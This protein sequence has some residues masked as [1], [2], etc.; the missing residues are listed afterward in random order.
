MHYQIAVLTTEYVK[1][2]MEHCLS[3]LDL[4]CSFQIC[5][6]HP[7]EDIEPV[8]HAIPQ[9]A[10]AILS[11]GKVFAEAISHDHPEDGRPLRPFGVD[12][13]AVHRLLWRLREESGELDC[14]RI[15]TDFLDLLHMDTHEF[16]V[17]DHAITLADAMT[18]EA[19]NYTTGTLALSEQ[20]QYQKLLS[21][22]KTGQFD[23]ILTRYSE[24]IPLLRE[25][26]VRAYYPY[27][28]IDSVRHACGDLL[29]KLEI[30]HLQEHQAAEIHINLWISNPVYSVDDLFERRCVRLQEALNEFFSGF[31][32]E[33]IIHRSHFGLDIL[34]DRKM[35]AQC[36]R[37]YTTCLLSEFLQSRLDFK[38][39]VGYGLGRSIYQARLNAINATRESEVSGG[40]FLINEKDELVGPL[41]R[42]SQL[43]VPT[44]GT[45]AYQNNQSGLSS[46]TINKVLS[47]L[48]STLEHQITAR[49]LALKL[50][51]THRSANH[52]LSA[53]RKAGLLQIVAERRT[54]SRGRPERVYARR[55]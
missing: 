49:T 19:R 33:H 45:F 43:T 16:M 29:H 52:F 24:L 35:V 34:T 38:V 23:L 30:R 7:F 53:M 8:Y 47:A 32:M 25:R 11:T 14:R 48:D 21:I 37:G 36:T 2:H 10:V 6:Y 1:R 12:D 26:G 54:T 50:S 22:W 18:N 55:E 27:P 40:S 17:E 13:A 3:Q 51:I 39:F 42:D 5:C 46:L 20:A 15:Y 41:G 28:S 9:D 31:P 4:D 44:T